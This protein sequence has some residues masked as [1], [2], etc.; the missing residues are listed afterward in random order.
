MSV[1]KLAKPVS[2]QHGEAL[3]QLLLQNRHRHV[4]STHSDQTQHLQSLMVWQTSRLKQTH[5]DLFSSERYQQA[6]HYF[7]EDLYLS[8]NAIQ[9][10]K[11]LERV[12]PTLVKLLPD[13]ML[14]TVANAVELNIL[15]AELDQQLADN[16]FRIAREKNT[17]SSITICHSSYVQAYRESAAGDLRVHQLNLINQIGSDLDHLVRIPLISWTL[18]LIRK[19]A[20]KKGLG[21]L[22]EFLERG[23]NTFKDLGGAKE[24]MSIISSREGQIIENLNSGHHSP[25]AIDTRI[26][27]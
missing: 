7:I 26:N 19:R 13:D 9:R 16:L 10:D 15:S 17:E 22:H 14:E 4:Q 18:R 11:D 25:F 23:F 12:F 8:P 2:G 6:A 1:D 24:F 27:L 3:R 20:H 5:A 21:S